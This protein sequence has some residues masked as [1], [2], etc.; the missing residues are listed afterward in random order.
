MKQ[1]TDSKQTIGVNDID[2][3]YNASAVKLFG[4]FSIDK[5]FLSGGG[6]WGR[7]AGYN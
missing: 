4:E 5:R 2:L 1:Q 6:G 3:I 7:A